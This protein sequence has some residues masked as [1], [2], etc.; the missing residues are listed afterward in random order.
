VLGVSAGVVL[1]RAILRVLRREGE[2]EAHRLAH[3]AEGRDARQQRGAVR[4]RRRGERQLLRAEP[5]D[6]AAGG[7]GAV[8]A[9]VAGD[10]RA[11]AEVVRRARAEER[12]AHLAVAPV[13][14]RRRAG[15]R[16]PGPRPSCT[17]RA[18]W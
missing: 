14:H 1:R 4:E 11:R 9:A 7:G 12:V 13:A 15:C 17:P 16:R 6:I 10:A 3:V 2:S 18:S 8:E 5:A